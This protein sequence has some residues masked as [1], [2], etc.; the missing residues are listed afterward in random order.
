MKDVV[1][2]QIEELLR[3]DFRALD[4]DGFTANGNDSATGIADESRRRKTGS[5]LNSPS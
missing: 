3:R 1:E 5:G 4:D 2:Q